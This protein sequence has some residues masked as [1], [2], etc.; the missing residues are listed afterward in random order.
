MTKNLEQVLPGVQKHVLLAPYTTFRIGGHAKYFL[1][2]ETNEDI[3]RAVEAAR[4]INIPFFILA[5]GSNV[6][7]SDKGFNGLVIYIQNTKFE[8]KKD[9]MYAQA[10]VVFGTIVKEA[11][12]Q[13]LAGLEWAGGLPG[14]VGGAI[15]G[16]AGA[17]G[18]EVKD[19][20]AEAECLDT[21]GTIRTL[22]NAECKFSYRSSVFKEK[23]WI[24]LSGTFQLQKGDKETIQRLAQEHI[25]YRKDRHPLEYPN[26]GS[27]FKNCN[28]KKM[29]APVQKQFRKKIKE[30]PFPV[31]PAAVLVANAGLAGMRVGDA[32]I[33]EKHTNYIVNRGNASSN[34]V[35]SL[36]K[37]V[38]NVIQKKFGVEL[39]E[40]VTLL[41]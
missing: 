1:I 32:Q 15:R 4:E 37:K 8:I 39:E 24:V 10:G 2:A 7:V 27:I 16:N 38:K 13:G 28:V 18:G 17:F 20:L 21:E 14:S 5:G 3:T 6:L 34:D 12:E 23:N 29:P 22:S 26:A 11:G 41:K 31:I 19:T 30:D 36:I 9:R 40:E 25:Q 33:S 35:L